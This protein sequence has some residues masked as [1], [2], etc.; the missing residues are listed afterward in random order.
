VDSSCNSKKFRTEGWV[1]DLSGRRLQILTTERK[2]IRGE[3]KNRLSVK[4][5]KGLQ[6]WGMAG[7]KRKR[8]ERKDRSGVLRVYI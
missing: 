7:V 4:V 1:K 6:E 5:G 3:K 8:S 2:G